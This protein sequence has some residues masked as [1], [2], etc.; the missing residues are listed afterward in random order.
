MREEIEKGGESKEGEREA[1]EYLNFGIYQ[2]TEQRDKALYEI[3]TALAKYLKER[4]NTLSFADL[5]SGGVPSGNL[6]KEKKPTS[7]TE[8]KEKEKEPVLTFTSAPSLGLRKQDEQPQALVFCKDHKEKEQEIHVAEKFVHEEKEEVD[9]QKKEQSSTFLS[10]SGNTFP[11]GDASTFS[12]AESNVSFGVPSEKAEEKQEP[13]VWFYFANH[14]VQPK[15]KR[16]LRHL[17]CFA[18]PM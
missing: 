17:L 6:A 12:L 16:K 9:K 18:R 5:L 1:V 2:T 13:N 14:Q 15:K 4:S 8:E 7:T 10:I 11:L 3:Q